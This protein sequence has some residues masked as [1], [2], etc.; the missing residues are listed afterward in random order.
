MVESSKVTTL[1]E[2]GRKKKDERTPAEAA[3]RD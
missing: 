1:Q 3:A 2:E